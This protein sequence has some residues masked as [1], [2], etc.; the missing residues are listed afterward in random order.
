MNGYLLFEL[1]VTRAK[2]DHMFGHDLTEL[3]SPAWFVD[4]AQ[5]QIPGADRLIS[6]CPVETPVVYCLAS[7][8]W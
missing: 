6:C 3:G 2:A 8:Q 5:L 1:S 7:T 4:Q